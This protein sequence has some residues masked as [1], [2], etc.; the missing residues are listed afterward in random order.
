[1]RHLSAQDAVLT[2]IVEL[3]G[4]VDF[5][6][7]PSGL[8]NVKQDL[9]WEFQGHLGANG[10]DTIHDKHAGISAFVNV[11]ADE[12]QRNAQMLAVGVLV[13]LT[14]GRLGKS[15]RHAEGLQEL[16]KYDMEMLGVTV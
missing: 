6:S 15:W 10:T 16:A 2:L 1:M 7:L 13:P 4:V 5:K 11:P 14:Y 9:V 12:S 3:E 8:H